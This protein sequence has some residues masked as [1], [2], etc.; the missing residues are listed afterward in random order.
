MRSTAYGAAPMS[1]AATDVS[2]AITSSQSK[3]GDN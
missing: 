1:Q 3:L 2:V